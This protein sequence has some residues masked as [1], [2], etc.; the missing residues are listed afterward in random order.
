VD[1]KAILSQLWGVLG[2]TGLA[3]V[4]V[5]A[6]MIHG[7]PGRFVVVKVGW[8]LPLP[9]IALGVCLIW[10]IVAMVSPCFVLDR[11]TRGIDAMGEKKCYERF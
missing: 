8:R 2:I 9:W 3:L 4:L 11:I 1:R 5:P 7:D 10:P 6:S